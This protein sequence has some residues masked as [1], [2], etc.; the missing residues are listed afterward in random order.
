MAASV[1]STR[2]FKTELRRRC[3][4]QE[5]GPVAPSYDCAGNRKRAKTGDVQIVNNAANRPTWWAGRACAD[6]R[7]ERTAL[8]MLCLADFYAGSDYVARS[9]TTNVHQAALIMFEILEV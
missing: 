4:T 6:H 7:E 1:T 3:T 5:D 9:Q 2:Y 8:P